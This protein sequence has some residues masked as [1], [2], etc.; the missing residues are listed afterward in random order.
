M[1][2]LIDDD[3]GMLDMCT[4]FLESKGYQIT[5][6]ASAAEALIKIKR[7]DHE[8]VISDCTMPG[9]SGLELSQT[10]RADPLTAHLPILLMSASMRSEVA[11]ST[12]YDTFL[13]KPFLAEKLLVEVQKLLAGIAGSSN[14]KH[15]V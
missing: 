14:N 15:G 10:L 7:G 11:N 8:L 3:V 2:M 12:C 1:I 13:R 5:P 9:M 6:A 4:L